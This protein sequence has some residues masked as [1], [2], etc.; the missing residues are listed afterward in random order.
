[1]TY[2]KSSYSS[3]VVSSSPCFRLQRARLV[4][5]FVV[6]S[7]LLAVGVAVAVR[8]R[9]AFST[10]S[11]FFIAFFPTLVGTLCFL[12]NATSVSVGAS[13]DFRKASVAIASPPAAL[14]RSP[15]ESA[16]SRSRSLPD[17][18]A[19]SGTKRENSALS[20]ESRLEP[21]DPARARTWCAW[22]HAMKSIFA[23]CRS[24]SAGH[25][26]GIPLR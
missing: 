7:S 2:V 26:T 17:H 8:I 16:R 24:S 6:Y 14:K 19:N 22:S 11:F 12:R 20:F 4:S 15:T 3:Q 23:G 1:M 13:L 10:S 21:C 5:G 9:S 25:W 18:S